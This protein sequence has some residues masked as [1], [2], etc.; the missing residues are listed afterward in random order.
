MSD[1]IGQQITSARTSPTLQTDPLPISPASRNLCKANNIA[2]SRLKNESVSTAAASLWII[3]DH[4]P[5]LYLDGATFAIVYVH[6]AQFGEHPEITLEDVPKLDCTLRLF[7][8]N[9]KSKLEMKA[10]RTWTPVRR[11]FVLC[12]PM[13]YIY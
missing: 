12:F 5:R 10:N 3:P 9:E 7:V 4:N 6:T 8:D 2:D 1:V 11:P 13:T